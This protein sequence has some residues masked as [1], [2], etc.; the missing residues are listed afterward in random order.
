[1]LAN[2]ITLLMEQPKELT[3]KLCRGFKEVPEFG[4]EPEK[5]WK[6]HFEDKVKNM[7]LVLVMLELEYKFAYKMTGQ[8]PH[9]ILRN[10]ADNK[11]RN[12]S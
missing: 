5:S 9:R 2:G 12:F 10:A 1:M 3:Q 8:V 6:C 11:H 4:I 7:N